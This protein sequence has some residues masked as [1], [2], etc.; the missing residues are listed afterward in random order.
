MWSKEVADPDLWLSLGTWA[1]ETRAVR[2]NVA[3][4]RTPPSAG[5]RRRIGANFAAGRNRSVE[6]LL[7]TMAFTPPPVTQIMASAV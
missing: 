3:A 4:L 2:A 6:E 5:R 1:Q 7:V